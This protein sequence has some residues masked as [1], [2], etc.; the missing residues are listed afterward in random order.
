MPLQLTTVAPSNFYFAVVAWCNSQQIGGNPKYVSTNAGWNDLIAQYVVPVI[1]NSQYAPA[2]I[3]A[4][5]A[6]ANSANLYL[7]SALNVNPGG[8]VGFTMTGPVSGGPMSVVAGSSTT[9]VYDF[10]MLEDYSVIIGSIV[11]INAIVPAGS[12]ISATC[13]PNTAGATTTVSIQVSATSG[14]AN[15]I[16]NIG[17]LMVDSFG[18]PY[19]TS[20]IFVIPVTITGGVT[21]G[22]Y[23]NGPFTATNPGAMTVG[24]AYTLTQTW[25]LPSGV[26]LAN[27]NWWSVWFVLAAL[28][29]TNSSGVNPPP[30]CPAGDFNYNTNTMYA[31]Q[32][33][34]ITVIQFPLGG[35]G[36]HGS[37]Y[38]TV[39]LPGTLITLSG[40]DAQL[41]LSS[42]KFLIPGTYQMVM[43][44]NYYNPTTG[45]NQFQTDTLGNQWYDMGEFVAS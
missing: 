14:A 17:I 13:T 29:P 24:T 5:R 31:F 18:A 8:F 22:T 11:S 3:V 45:F 30:N 32:A 21:S 1:M 4:L 26:G 33:D 6:A 20:N 28:A 25:T 16:V 44:V 43:R 35:S 38:W 41:V 10:T 27:I 34:G 15:G 23:T 2:N 36:D 42:T 37:S 19:N 39:N 12:G 40:S 7:Q 9:L